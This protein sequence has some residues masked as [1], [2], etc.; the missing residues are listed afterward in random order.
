MALDR[1]ALVL[2]AV[3]LLINLMFANYV[4]KEILM[5]KAFRIVII[6]WKIYFKL[7]NII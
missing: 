7:C 6:I 2:H 4:A 1:I 5:L 3:L